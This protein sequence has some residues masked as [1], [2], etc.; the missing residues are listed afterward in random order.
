MTLEAQLKATPK[1]LSRF[2][3]NPV[4]RRYHWRVNGHPVPPSTVR[5]ALDSAIERSAY[6]M[7]AL[8]ARLEDGTITIHKWR[9]G[10]AQ[11][12]RVMHSASAAA[13]RGGW[14]QMSPA[15]WGRVGA[16]MR[17]QYRYLDRFAAQLANGE[18][19]LDGSFRVRCGMYAEASRG[20]YEETRRQLER[21]GGMEEERRILHALE[22]CGDCLNYAFQGWQPI[23]TLPEIGD[24][25]CRVNCKCTFDYRKIPPVA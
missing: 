2:R 9:K 14:H 21:E 5:A 1:E 18:Q 7:G 6:D 11:S 23:G 16:R 13:G 4:D 17:Q 3:W 22:S 20:T 19:R 10:M 8:A 12:M 24:S 25:Q 15:D